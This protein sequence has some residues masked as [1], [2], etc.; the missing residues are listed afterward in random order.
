MKIDSALITD[1]VIIQFPLKFYCLFLSDVKEKIFDIFDFFNIQTTIRLKN[2]K[3]CIRIA[4]KYQP[5]VIRACIVVSQT[6]YVSIEKG[7][8]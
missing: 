8:I 4:Y 5:A 1:A 2:E 7:G 3:T 6:H